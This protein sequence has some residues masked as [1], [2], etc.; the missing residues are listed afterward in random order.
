MRP[1]YFLTIAHSFFSYHNIICV[2]LSP[3]T[4]VFIRFTIVILPY[5]LNFTS[6]QIA[7]LADL[8]ESDYIIVDLSSAHPSFGVIR[9]YRLMPRQHDTPPHRTGGGL[10]I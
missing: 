10:R 5:R 4:L 8:L 9:H 2:H 6:T 7:I 3:L 1:I